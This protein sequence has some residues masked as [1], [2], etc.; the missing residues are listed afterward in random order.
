MPA[1]SRAIPGRWVFKK[2]LNPD[3]S[4]RYKARWVIRGNLL[5]KSAYEGTTYAPVV[6]P[7]TSRIL[8]ALSAQKGWHI[9]QADA[10]LAF[11]NAKLKCQPIYMHQP[12]GFI[13]GEPGVLVCLLQQ[14]LY[15]L[16]PSARLWYDDQKL[17]LNPL[18]LKLHP[19]TLLYSYTRRRSY[20]LPLMSTTS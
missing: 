18:D 4:I 11:L 8:L 16:T 20:I 10:V 5:D 2:Q 15:G 9:I 13:E 14:S 19:M 6:D 7:T 17:I 3:D 12:L 1:G